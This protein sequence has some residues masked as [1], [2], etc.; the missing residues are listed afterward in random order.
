MNTALTDW[1]GERIVIMVGR[2]IW[3]GELY[4]E[5]GPFALLRDVTQVLDHTAT[6]ITEEIQWGQGRFNA[7]ALDAFFLESEVAWTPKT[8]AKKSRKAASST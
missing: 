1:V 8:T 5:R 3:R 4:E 7:G 6:A 2:F